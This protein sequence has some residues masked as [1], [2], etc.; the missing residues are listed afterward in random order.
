MIHT[1]SQFR[2]VSPSLS[3][4]VKFYK[5]NICSFRELHFY[6]FDILWVFVIVLI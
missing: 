3:E 2:L 1:F 5:I 6:L 4:L